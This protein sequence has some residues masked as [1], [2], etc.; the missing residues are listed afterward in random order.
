MRTKNKTSIRK[1][2]FNTIKYDQLLEI[3][4][5]NQEDDIEVFNEWF[6]YDYH[7]SEDEINFLKQ[8]IARYR[9]YVPHFLEEE[10]KAKYIIPI[11]NKVDFFAT[12]FKDW[13]ERTIKGTINGVELSGI[14]DFMVAKG[15]KEPST[16][17]FFIQEFKQSKP[18]QDPQD[19]LLA[20]LI[21][22]IEK[23]KHKIIY[24]SYIIGAIW[25]FVILKKEKGNTYTY[26]ESKAF[27]S[28]WYD[29]LKQIY[30]NLQAV[31]A[32]YCKD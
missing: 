26:F 1:I 30:I 25:K 10:L 11:I 3:V 12:H 14:V 8:L 13:Y 9:F 16:P 18:S 31:K 17:Y 15:V 19:Q 6:T 32:L 24:G 5:I 23:N 29:D 4:S 21:V 7:L 28:L 22:S 27:D 20:E 2:S